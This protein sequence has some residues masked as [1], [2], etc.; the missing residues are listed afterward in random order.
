MQAEQI[1]K[2]RNTTVVDILEFCKANPIMVFQAADCFNCPIAQYA[3]EVLGIKEAEIDWGGLYY[4]SYDGGSA[5]PIPMNDD[6][7]YG[8]MH[9]LD[10][11]HTLHQSLTGAEI[12]KWWSE[13]D[14]R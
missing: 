11:V 8:F 1:E 9:Q 6:L 5:L 4:T 7:I 13:R 2:I 12:V 3:H 14:A 10:R